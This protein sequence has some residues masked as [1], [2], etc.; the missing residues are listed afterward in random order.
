MP[1]R[2]PTLPWTSRAPALLLLIGCHHEPEVYSESCAVCPACTLEEIEPTSKEH[3]SYSI[4]YPDPPPTSGDHDPCW[5]EWGVHAEEVRDEQWV[6]NLEHGGVVFLYNCPDGCA[7][8]VATLTS[9]TEAHPGQ[10][11]LTPYSEMSSSFAAVSWGWRMLTDCVEPDG[12]S[13]FFDAHVDQ[14]PESET[15]DPSA[16][17]E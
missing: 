3:V 16:S 15:D 13:D 2:P 12:F 17:C 9:L 7:D 10:A 5:A 1:A 14:A 8:E 4:D 11:L 6:H